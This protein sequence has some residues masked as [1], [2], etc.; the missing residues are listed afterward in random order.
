MIYLDNAATTRPS[1]GALARAQHYLT[2]CYY[3]PSALYGGG[4]EAARLAALAAGWAAAGRGGS[5]ASW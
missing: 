1:E 3:N 5:S 2:E 4:A